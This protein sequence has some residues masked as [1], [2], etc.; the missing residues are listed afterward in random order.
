MLAVFQVQTSN[1]QNSERTGA[2][3]SPQ[4]LSA[5]LHAPLLATNKKEFRL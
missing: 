5:N 2:R 3:F 4:K 1:L